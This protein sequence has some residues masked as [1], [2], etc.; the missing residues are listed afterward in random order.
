MYDNNCTSQITWID[1]AG[2]ACLVF[3]PI[4]FNTFN[5]IEGK[6][7]TRFKGQTLEAYL[8]EL[9]TVPSP[10]NFYW[11]NMAKEGGGLDTNDAV[12]R[13]YWN[14][15]LGN[16]C[17]FPCG[18]EEICDCE[19]HN[20]TDI[21][22]TVR[23]AA[24]AASMVNFPYMPLIVMV[25]P[26][27]TIS[28]IGANNLYRYMYLVHCNVRMRPA[29]PSDPHISWRL[30]AHMGQYKSK[31][32]R[33]RIHGNA[34]K[35]RNG[36]WG[37]V[38]SGTISRA[39]N[40]GT[41]GVWS[42]RSSAHITEGHDSLE[43]STFLTIR[44]WPLRSRWMG[45]EPWKWAG[46]CQVQTHCTRSLGRA[47]SRPGYD[48]TGHMTIWRSG[49]GFMDAISQCIDDSSERSSGCSSAPGVLWQTCQK[50]WLIESKSKMT[51]SRYSSCKP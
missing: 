14:R 20:R 5:T 23:H 34:G 19:V 43:G 40:N 48:D 15:Y 16:N 9:S 32:T 35:V 24:V 1:F 10:W 41:D 31:H 26:T 38:L 2:T 33:D 11:N 46:Y 12:F 28:E 45:T 47:T 13:Q 42:C 51:R 44:L 49:E 4:P 7:A 3:E 36:T 29:W 25:P 6:I 39:R 50:N 18:S 17:W 30:N 37:V 21:F 22:S 27:R 8:L